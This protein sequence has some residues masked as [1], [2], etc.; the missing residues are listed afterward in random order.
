VRLHVE[1][2]GGG[3]LRADANATLKVGPAR[4]ARRVKGRR[5]RLLTRTVATTKP[6]MNASA[7]G[8]TTLVLTPASSYAALTERPGGL[9]ANAEVSF[10][11]PGHSTLRERVEV[12]FV[13]KHRAKARGGRRR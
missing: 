2:P 4:S 3:T 13:R 12:S 6:L 1:V 5:A 8:L 10:A 9:T 11:S 7:G